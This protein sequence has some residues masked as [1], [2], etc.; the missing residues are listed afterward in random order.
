MTKECALDIIREHLTNL[1]SN[2]DI[3]ERGTCTVVYALEKIVVPM[4]ENSI[5]REVNQ[6][7]N[8][9]RKMRY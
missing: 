7:E 1:H 4:L 3:Y 8:T 9:V 2:A 5:E 6:H